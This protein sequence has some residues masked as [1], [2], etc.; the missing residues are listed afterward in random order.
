[1]RET[2]DYQCSSLPPRKGEWI[3][4]TS[5]D[6]GIPSFVLFRLLTEGYPWYQVSALLRTHWLKY[7][8]HNQ[9]PSTLTFRILG[10][11]SEHTQSSQGD[12]QKRCHTG[13]GYEVSSKRLMSKVWSPE[14]VWSPLLKG[15]WTMKWVMENVPWEGV[16]HPLPLP[17]TT[18]QIPWGEHLCSDVLPPMFCLATGSGPM[19]LRKH[20][21][22]FLNLQP[23]VSLAC[24]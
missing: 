16:S 17:P 15:D 18:S 10:K 8:S 2:H 23:Q 3:N 6:W 21:L 13:S 11:T 24:F 4:S 20:G 5:A 9:M 14:W 7:S 1:M 19:I 22:R 12:T